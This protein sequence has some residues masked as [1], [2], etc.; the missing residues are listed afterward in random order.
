ML[1]CGYIGECEI[2]YEYIVEKISVNFIG[3]LNKCEVICFR[4]DV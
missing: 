4:F 1:K 3:K 2:I